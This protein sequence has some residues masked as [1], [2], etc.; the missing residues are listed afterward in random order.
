MAPFFVF[1]VLCLFLWS[2]DDYWYYSVFTLLMLMF[3]EGMMCKQ[4]QASLTMLRNMRRPPVR[5]NVYRA[6]AWVSISSDML[7]P[8]DLISLT[9]DFGRKKVSGRSGGRSEETDSIVPCDAL[10]VRGSC[11][12]N[13]AMLTGESVPQMKET[14]RT[15]TTSAGVSGGADDYVDLGT[16]SHIEAQWKRHMVFS[17][18]SLL[19]HTERV[20][21]DVASSSFS[22]TASQLPS[23]PDGG[24][25]AVVI[26][27]GFGTSQ[28][29]KLKTLISTIFHFISVLFINEFLV[30]FRRED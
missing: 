9:A 11:V 16:E 24:C 13:E 27:T 22:S 10:L 26:R 15:R 7:V 23:A 29:S 28:V 25:V 2:L 12:V 3:F 8:G 18:T 14:L 19:I 21:A 4:R 20:D 6:G 30:F 1:Q 5:I 17:G